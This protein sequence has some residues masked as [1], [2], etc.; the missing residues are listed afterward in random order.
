[1]K[2]TKAK[3]ARDLA[4]L[5]ASLAEGVKYAQGRRAKVRVETLYVPLTGRDVKAA[6]AVL[7]VSQPKFA[8]LMVVSPET[9]K[10][11]EQNRNPIPAAVGYWVAAL[12]SR[13]E[14]AKKLLFE[15]ASHA[16]QA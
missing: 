12:T 11:W 10:K 14:V 4:E 6:R 13:P 9:V 8:R 5:K 7:Q 2:K 16:I 3:E 15:M 1:M